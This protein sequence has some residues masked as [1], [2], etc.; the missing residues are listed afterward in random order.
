MTVGRKKTTRTCQQGQDNKDIKHEATG[1]RQHGQGN[2][3]ITARIN[4]DRK[5]LDEKTAW[6]SIRQRKR[7]RGQD[8]WKQ[9]VKSW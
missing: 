4:Q 3:N 6:A 5:R 1:T 2:C 9:R 8:I 7:Q